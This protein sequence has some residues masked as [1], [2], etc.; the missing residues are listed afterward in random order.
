MLYIKHCRDQEKV[1]FPIYHL[2]VPKSWVNE[3]ILFFV[4]WNIQHIVCYWEQRIIFMGKEGSAAACR[5]RIPAFVKLVP[6]LF[7]TVCSAEIQQLQKEIDHLKKPR[8]IFDLDDYPADVSSSPWCLEL[9]IIFLLFMHILP[10]IHISWHRLL[11]FW[12][13]WP[14][15]M[16]S[17]RR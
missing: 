9:L 11:R 17:R 13:I 8:Q 4:Q 6:L 2:Y 16:L 15:T 14:L 1:S 3:I 5:R 7:N 12:S 10:R